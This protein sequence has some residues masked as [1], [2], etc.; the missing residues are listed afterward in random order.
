MSFDVVWWDYFAVK[1]VFSCICSALLEYNSRI[2][3]G[4]R[5]DIYFGIHE[6]S[7]K[8]SLHCT[9][10]KFPVLFGNFPVGNSGELLFPGCRCDRRPKYAAQGVLPAGS[11]S[12]RESSPRDGLH[13]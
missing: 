7:K 2:L 11:Q 6:R 10:G 4:C 8:I 9:S 13:L 1:R 5:H 3:E 12:V